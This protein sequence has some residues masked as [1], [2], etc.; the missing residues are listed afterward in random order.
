MLVESRLKTRQAVLYAFFGIVFIVDTFR[1][2]WSS[3]VFMLSLLAV[4][5]GSKVDVSGV[6]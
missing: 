6:D 1:T 3:E 4:V 5:S 2:R